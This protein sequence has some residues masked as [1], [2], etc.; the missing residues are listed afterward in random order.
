MLARRSFQPLLGSSPWRIGSGG[1]F[2]N[3]EAFL[4]HVRDDKA[5]QFYAISP[6]DSED[7]TPNDLWKTVSQQ[8]AE[9]NED[10]RFVAI[11]G[12]QWQGDSGEEGLRHF[13]YSKDMKQI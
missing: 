9:F 7:E 10:D 3:I 13:I 4:R 1:R 12:F 8:V 5:L 6:F 11:L 2:E